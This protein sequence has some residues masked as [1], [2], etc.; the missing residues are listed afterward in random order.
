MNL[1]RKQFMVSILFL[2]PAAAIFILF[3]YVPFLQ[4]IYYSFTDWNGVGKP[5]F[6]GWANY[7]HIWKDPHM[8]DGLWNSLKM[9]AFGLVVQNPLALLAAVLLNRQFRTRSFIRTAF[10]LPVIISLVVASVVWGQMLQYDG[11][12]NEVMIRIGLE[13]ITEDWLGNV[14]T[15]FPAIILLTQW[16]AIGYCAI[17]YL[18]GLQAIPQDMYEAAEI[19]GARGWSLFRFITLPMLMPAVTIVLFLTVVGSL[20]LF[21]LPYILTNG[22]P[23]TSSYTLFLAVYNAAFKDNNYGYATAG[24]IVLAIFIVIVSIVQLSATRRKEVE[25]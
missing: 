10:Y 20:K 12:I 23:G 4:S 25:L 14:W 22:G 15:S 3:F 5:K 21:D 2:I 7:A 24:G 19:E 8:T 18:A 16:Q 11:F 9:A 1:N 13:S 17:I 6:I